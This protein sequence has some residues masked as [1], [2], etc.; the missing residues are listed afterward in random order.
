MTIYPLLF[1][2][3]AAALIYQIVWVR[4]LGLSISS[5]S[6]SVSIVVGTFFVGMALGS[7]LTTRYRRLRENYFHSYLIAEL[8]IAGSA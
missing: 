1:L 4:L 7:E 2:S 5:T 6:I 8:L 3:G